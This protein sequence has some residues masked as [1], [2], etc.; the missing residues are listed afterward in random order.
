MDPGAQ[1]ELPSVIVVLRFP[2]DCKSGL[3]V[4]VSAH[5]GQAVKDQAAR[6]AAG[7]LPRVAFNFNAQRASV[8]W[9][10]AGRRRQ[11]ERG[12]QAANCNLP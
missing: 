2:F 3:R 4:S 7:T 9:T 11:N 1:T 6:Q 10:R 5:R 8:V 12:N